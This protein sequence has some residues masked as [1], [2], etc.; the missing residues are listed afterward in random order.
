LSE[1]RRKRELSFELLEANRLSQNLFSEETLKIQ[2]NLAR[3][4]ASAR[5]DMVVVLQNEEG[6]IAGI[7]YLQRFSPNYARKIRVLFFRKILPLLMAFKHFLFVT[8][9][10]DHT[11]YATQ[12]EVKKAEQ[13]AWNRLNNALRREFPWVCFIKT[14][15][16]QSNGKG[17]HL[18]VLLCGVR[19][20][21]KEWFQKYWIEP[22]GWGIEI[23]QPRAKDARS[24]LR[25]L[26][27][28]IAKSSLR[29]DE[30]E[31]LSVSQIVNWA[32]M[33]RAFSMS[34]K[35][36]EG[37]LGFPK[38]NSTHQWVFLGVMPLSE[39]LGKS[40]DEVLEYLLARE[41]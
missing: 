30:H 22:S 8:F 40:R 29:E 36:S 34:R 26:L 20:I 16:W 15:E 6:D 11:R 4:Y 9:T 23:E 38:T 24:V 7:P 37:R 5:A 27:K 2:C 13:E 32:T 18:H 14:V 3:E 25:Y 12:V 10:V 21:K 31:D 1:S 17:A 39:Y 19:Y 33:T 28:Y 41:F 35:L